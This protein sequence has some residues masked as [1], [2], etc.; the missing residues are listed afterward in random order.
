MNGAHLHLVLNHVPVLGGL[1]VLL[2]M[3]IAKLKDNPAITKLTLQFMVLVGVASFAAYFSGEPA[4]ELVEHLPGI[5][6]SLIERHERFALYGLVTTEILAALGI[7]GLF[8]LRVNPERIAKYWIAATAVAIL[9][10]GLM[11]TTANYGGEI[12]HTEIRQATPA[13]SNPQP[14]LSSESDDD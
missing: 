5:S 3:G 9:N 8:V 2:L 4:E 7:V 6:E 14:P 10:A 12:R 13:A 1:A 11:L